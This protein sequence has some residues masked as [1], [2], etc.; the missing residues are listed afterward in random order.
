MQLKVI[1][2]D[3]STEEYLHTK[4]LG[5]FNNALAAINQ[6]NV[7]V[8][9]QFAEAITFYLYQKRTYITITTDEV[10]LMIQAVLTA[11]GYEN[12][13]LALNEHRMNR[14]LQRK[15]VVVVYNDRFADDPNLTDCQW[16]KSQIVKD[17][18]VNDNINR[19]IARVIASS[20]EE[21]VFNIGVSRIRRSLI[22]QLVMADTDAML[23]AQEQ[24]QAT[25]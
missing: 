16:D 10:H 21:K 8:A 25:V 11:T 1:K 3:V 20:V 13:S 5:T 7:F 2:I 18:M 12:A 14:K 23:Q 22:K 6:S 15:R 24:L 9:E 4:V 17:L 19:H